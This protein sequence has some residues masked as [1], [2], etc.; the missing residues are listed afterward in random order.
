MTHVLKSDFASET[1]S[2]SQQCHI[3]S[4]H[5]SAV[6]GH[7]SLTLPRLASAL[8]HLRDPWA[9]PR[10]SGLCDDT[11]HCAAGGRVQVLRRFGLLG[12]EEV[13]RLEGLGE[14]VQVA[15]LT[16]AADDDV[17]GE[18]PEEFLDPITF[19]LMD[20]P[21]LLPRQCAPPLL[22]NHTCPVAEFL[23]SPPR[24]KIMR[25]PGDVSE[26]ALAL[27]QAGRVSFSCN[28]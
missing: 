10:T 8:Q 28:N 9:V 3:E 19:D 18:A 5:R 20:D 6:G 23:T 13:D 24:T 21:V 25:G 14:R 12:E 2:S 11:I 1:S 7:H 27:Y 22:L 16:R 15:R 26:A 4:T 17:L